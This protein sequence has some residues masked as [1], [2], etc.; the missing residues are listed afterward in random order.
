VLDVRRPEGVSRADY[1]NQVNEIITRTGWFLQAV[2][3]DRLRPPWAY[4]VGLTMAGHPELVA[5][6][7][8][9][10]RAADLLNGVAEHVMR[11]KASGEQIPLCG[12]SLIEIVKLREPSAHLMMAIELYGRTVRALQLVHADDRG[13]RPWDLG[14]RGGRRGQPSSVPGPWPSGRRGTFPPKCPAG[15]GLTGRG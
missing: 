6:G 14:Y 12:G 11:A 1:L 2:Q 9:F 15:G 8:S 3:G 4:T 5:T 13:H 10:H 7:L